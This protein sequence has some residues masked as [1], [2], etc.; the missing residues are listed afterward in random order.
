MPI[1]GANISECQPTEA[2]VY[3]LTVTF[4]DGEV[5]TSNEVTLVAY[6]SYQ[7]IINDEICEGDDYTMHGFNLIHPAFGTY[8]ES[9]Y[10]QTEYG[11]D[12]IITLNLLVHEIPVVQ[13]HIDT[14][15]NGGI[16]FMLSATGANSYE[17][18]TGETTAYIMVSPSEPTTY[19]VIGTS[20]SGC[21]DS[22][23]VIVS[24]GT[25]IEE[26]LT[27]STEL[28]PNPAHDKLF[29]KASEPIMMVE[30][31]TVTGNLVYKHANRCS[32][33]E[34]SVNDFAPGVYVVRIVSE[35]STETKRFIVE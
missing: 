34:I 4:E 22:A 14:I 31:Y 17:W 10:F 29:V 21:S 8:N 23:E 35:T 12:S 20:N 9:L 2:G 25:G 3:T 30:I 18:S 15:I 5:L 32:E 33:T 24:G 7:T 26:N 28:Y 11:C 13:I 1:A 16:S 6:P 19:S 27:L